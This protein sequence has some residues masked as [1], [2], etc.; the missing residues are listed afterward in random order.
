MLPYEKS[1]P[2]ADPGNW[3]P[4]IT[5]KT[6]KAEKLVRQFR[7]IPFRQLSPASLNSPNITYSKPADSTDEWSML[8]PF[9]QACTHVQPPALTI[10]YTDIKSP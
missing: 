10:H 7:P 4:P 1:H 9:S 3:F 8:R 2:S 5:I 6:N